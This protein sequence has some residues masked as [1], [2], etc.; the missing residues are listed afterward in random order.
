[1]RDWLITCGVF[2]QLSSQKKVR[3]RN[4]DTGPGVF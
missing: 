2:E 3:A 4:V 1:M